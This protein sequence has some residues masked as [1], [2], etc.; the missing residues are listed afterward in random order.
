M[1]V[2]QDKLMDLMKKGQKTDTPSPTPATPATPG[3]STPEAPP[4]AAPMSTPEKQMGTREA[5]MINISI[6]LD[7]LDQSLPAVGAESDEGKA[8]MEASRKLGGL[9]AASVTKLEN[10]SSQRFC[11]C[12]RRY[13]RPVA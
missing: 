10:S 4:M 5:A 13:P 6:A 3:T 7:L 11:K 8:I 1:S 9:L 2:P 12:C